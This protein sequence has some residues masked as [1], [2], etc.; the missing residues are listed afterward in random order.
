MQL[1]RENQP[2]QTESYTQSSQ[3]FLADDYVQPDA[4]RKP[5]K[6]KN[7]FPLLELTFVLIIIGGLASLVLPNFLNCANK[8]KQ[9]EAK[10]YVGSM[11]RGQQAFFAEKGAFSDSIEKLGL[12]IKTQT[13]NFNYSVR[14]TKL[15]AFNYGIARKDASKP[16]KSYVGAVFVVPSTSVKPIT[17]QDELTTLAILCEA[18]ALGISKPDEPIYQNGKLSCGS[19]TTD[20]LSNPPIK[21]Q[22]LP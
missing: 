17:T 2:E 12:G 6:K 4:Q 20:I 11:N 5:Y 10:H 3:D 7:R 18:N 1:K 16:L 14:V 13:T 9:S 15:A 22:V 21:K 8:A 19:N